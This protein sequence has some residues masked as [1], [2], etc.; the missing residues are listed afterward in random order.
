M[1]EN[2]SGTVGYAGLSAEMLISRAKALFAQAQP[3]VPERFSAFLPLF[4]AELVQ[5]MDYLGIR[6]GAH[7]APHAGVVCGG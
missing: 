7:V 3:P 4:P 2:A 6:H 5:N 1:E